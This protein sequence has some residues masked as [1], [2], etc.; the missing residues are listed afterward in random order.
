MNDHPIREE[1]SGVTTDEVKFSDPD[2]GTL[3]IELTVGWTSEETLDHIHDPGM[4]T[5][6]FR[7]ELLTLTEL[8]ESGLLR[9]LAHDFLSS[10]RQRKAF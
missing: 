7:S 6:K 8:L 4:V 3:G 1:F 2:F 9:F 5:F 10:P